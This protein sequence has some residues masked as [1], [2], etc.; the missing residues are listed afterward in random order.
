MHPPLHIMPNPARAGKS[1][2]DVGC[3]SGT[4]APEAVRRAAPAGVEDLIALRDAHRILPRRQGIQAPGQ[5]AV[6]VL[7]ILQTH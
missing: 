2:G 7:H 4:D 1:A 3:H 5:I 6:D